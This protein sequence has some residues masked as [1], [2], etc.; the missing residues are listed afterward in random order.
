MT[1]KDD[2]LWQY[3]D[4]F[5]NTDTG[6]H[7]NVIQRAMAEVYQHHPP[8]AS[9]DKME[10]GKKI[11]KWFYNHYIHPKC[12]Y[13]KF[14]HKWSTQ[15]VF[16]Q[17]HCDE[18]MV[19]ATDMSGKELGKPGFLGALQ[20]ATTV[21]LDGLSAE[22]CDKYAEA[23]AE[24]SAQAPP[25][26]HP[27]PGVMAL[28]MQKWIIQDFQRQLF[29]TCGIHTLVLTAYKGEDQDLNICLLSRD[30]VEKVINNGKSFLNF[31]PQ[32]KDSDLWEQWR[33]F[34]IQC[35]SD[36]VNADP[37][38]PDCT[39]TIN[40]RIPIFKDNTGCP[41]LPDITPSHNFKAKVV[42]SMLREYCTAHICENCIISSLNVH[43]INCAIQ[44]MLQEIQ[45][46][47]YHG[48]EW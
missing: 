46:G 36:V 2:I 42:Q 47:G 17:L 40:K 25:P 33:Q 22:D 37:P 3:L 26:P 6:S 41:T 38:V 21:L 34:G 28:S 13:T 12:Q 1:E 31:C 39:W 11:Q 19:L 15:N 27:N 48:V 43:I 7:A 9:F 10:V 18:I 5:Q 20:D 8:N 32:W 23:A 4:E 14:M 29:K 24:W 35:F 30:D 16:F 45:Q 44:D